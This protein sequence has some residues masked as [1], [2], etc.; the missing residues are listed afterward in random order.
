MLSRSNE[1]SAR[2]EE[3]DKNY[4]DRETD[5]LSAVKAMPERRIPMIF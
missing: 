5:E 3:G 2:A 4:K 1:F